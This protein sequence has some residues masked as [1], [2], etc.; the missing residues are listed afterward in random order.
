M[1]TLLFSLITLLFAQHVTAQEGEDR[2]TILNDSVRLVE[3]IGK[4]DKVLSRHFF[5]GER[6][7]GVWQDFD[8]KGKL[9]NERDFWPMHYGDSTLSLTV[10]AMDINTCTTPAVFPG[11]DNAFFKYL[12]T[13]IRY[14]QEAVDAG[15]MGRVLV[16]GVIDESGDWSTVTILRSA[17]PYLDHEAWRVLE[18]MPNWTPATVDGKPV[19]VR[20]VIPV[21]FTLR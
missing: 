8:H 18:K 10:G 19:K 9:I 1:R 15:I 17:H 20:F 6:P 3:R 11:G 7:V 13:N 14:P 5:I 16:Q 4:K 12:G 2:V 21:N